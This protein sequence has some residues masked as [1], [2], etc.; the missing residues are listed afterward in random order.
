[1]YCILPYDEMLCI[2]GMPSVYYNKLHIIERLCQLELLS[3]DVN[4]CIANEIVDHPIHPSW[5]KISLL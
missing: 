1:M 3:Y 4:E 2:Q 5:I